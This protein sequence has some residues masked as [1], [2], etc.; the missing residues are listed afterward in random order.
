MYDHAPLSL[1]VNLLVPVLVSIPLTHEVPLHILLVWC[2]SVAIIA[3]IRFFLLRRRQS[4]HLNNKEQFKDQTNVYI[5]FTVFQGLVWGIGSVILLDTVTDFNRVLVLVLIAGISAGAIPLLGAMLPAYTAY[6][7]SATLPVEVWIF[8][9]GGI[10][11]WTLGVIGCVFIYVCFM[12]AKRFNGVLTRSLLPE[13]DETG[14][15]A[16]PGGS[17]DASADDPNSRPRV[18]RDVRERAK[19]EQVITTLSAG[20]V[21]LTVGEIDGGIRQSL[22]KIGSHACIDRSYIYLFNDENDAGRITH[23]W[24]RNGVS[25]RVSADFKEL[26]LS[27]N[28]IHRGRSVCLRSQTEMPVE[29]GAERELFDREKL[30]SWIAVPLIADGKARGFLG[31]DALEREISWSE[32]IIA[33]LRIAGAALMNALERKRDEVIIQCQAYQDP[34]TSLP[35]RRRF[36]ARMEQVF[37]VCRRQSTKAA[38][39]FID[40]DYFKKINDSLGHAAGDALLQLIAQRLQSGLRG[41]DMACRLGGDEF[42]IL[43]TDLGQNSPE[44]EQSA[45]SLA[46][47]V[48]RELSLPYEI[49]GREVNITLSMGV[50]VF[51]S[52]CT[53]SEAVISNA[54]SAMYRAKNCGRNFIQ[55]FEPDVYASA[56]SRLQLDEGLRDA[57]RFDKFEFYAQSQV[58]SYRDVIT[59][60]LL[61]RW[62]SDNQ[63]IV[64]SKDFITHAEDL[65]LIMDIDDWVMK[66]ACQLV[67]HQKRISHHKNISYAINIS[68]PQF[69]KKEFTDLV[70]NALGHSG[71]SGG[72]FEFEIRES[73]FAQNRE[74]VLEKM[75]TLRAMGVG[76]VLDGFGIGHSSLASL[77]YLPINKIKID[78]SFVRGV[79][80]N[81]D[82]AAIV[83]AIVAVGDRFELEVVAEGVENDAQ[84]EFLHSRGIGLFQGHYFGRPRPLLSN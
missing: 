43:L 32:D 40:I 11:F 13:V 23:Q 63:G 17:Y 48:H 76:I 83:E 27:I 75:N 30:K 4:N 51:P 81:Q 46:R 77:R 33:L 73:I 78:Q 20:F 29:A 49:N 15:L 6:L 47:R 84:F 54:D 58:N 22:A 82:D 38:I 68:A 14:A 60:E 52:K 44:P 50:E 66:K 59:D 65:G 57:L 5:V 31:F 18:E 21:R 34:L 16:F 80:K 42:I 55:L 24:C 79:E 70:S 10:Q 61:L 64:E 53:T 37:K 39:L 35:N 2:S 7:L 71:V 45:F 36:M 69:L 19:M 67:K 9:Q 62:N 1:L 56:R 8:T 26:N 41:G 25:P 3:L 12:G 72:F 74:Q 28:N